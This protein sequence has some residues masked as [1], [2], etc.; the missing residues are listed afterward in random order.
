MLSAARRR[1][2][3]TPPRPQSAEVLALVETWQKV[4]V[5]V[6][7]LLITL[8]FWPGIRTLMKQSQEAEKDWPAVL[9]PL[10]IVIV[11]VLFLLAVV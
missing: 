11:F 6:L 1:V 4:L 7:A 3:S 8:W 5:G 2:A 10:L 9:V